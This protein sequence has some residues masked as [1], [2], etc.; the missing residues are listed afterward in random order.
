MDQTAISSILLGL[1]GVP[2][3][4][5][6]AAWGVGIYNYMA[7]MADG[8][9]NSP[10]AERV[11]VLFFSDWLWH[12]RALTEQGR[13]HRERFIRSFF[14]FIGSLMVFVILVGAG[15]YLKK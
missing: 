11:F 10:T 7:M 6:I 4:V 5:A 13:R 3:V 2:F 12:P 15:H 1:A 8:Q 14:T 9:R